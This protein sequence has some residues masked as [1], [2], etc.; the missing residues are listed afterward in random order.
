MGFMMQLND[1]EKALLKAK[2]LEDLANS[3]ALNKMWT[4]THP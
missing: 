2:T 4:W 3:P 1:L